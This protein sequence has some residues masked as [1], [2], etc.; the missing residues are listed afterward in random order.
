MSLPLVTLLA[1]VC[2]LLGGWVCW[3]RRETTDAARVESL[4][5]AVS[6]RTDGGERRGA[7]DARAR[8]ADRRP[9]GGERQPEESAADGGRLS[10]VVGTLYGREHKTSK[11]YG[12]MRWVTSVD[13][14]DI[15]ILYVIFGL[16]AGLWGATDAMMIR[17]ELFTPTTDVWDADTYNALFTTHGLTM[18]FFFVTPV[19]TGLANYFLPI[20]VDADDMA[21]PRINAIAFWLLPPS[22]VL[23]RAGLL[24]E[25][26]AKM[27][28]AVGPRI[29]FLYALEPPTPG[30]TLYVPR[31]VQLAN[32]QVDLLILGLHLSGLA[33]V[34]GAVNIIV[35]IFTERGE[36]VGWSNLDIFSWSLLTTSGIILFAF[37]LLGSALLM[38]LLD[39]NFGTTFFA[40]EAGGPILWQHLFWFFGHPEVYIL[41]LPAFGLTSQILPKFAGRRLF[42][43]KFIVYSTLAIGVL[44]FG[45]W[46]HHM[47]ATGIDPRLRAS[48]MA[49]SIAI[50]VPSAVKTFNWMATLWNGSVRLEAPMQFLIGGIGLF[51]VGG[52]TGIFLASI[53]VDL[54]LHGTYYIVAHFHFIVVGIIAFSMFAASYY[55]YPLLTGRMYDRR[56]ATVHSVLSIGGVMLTFFP[57]FLVG[58][59]GL[60]RRSAGYPAEFTLLQQVATVGAF[61]L[62]VSVGIWLFNMV[63]SFRTGGVVRDPDPWNLKETGQFSREWQWFEDRMSQDLSRPHALADGGR[64]T[65]DVVADEADGGGDA[66]GDGSADAEDD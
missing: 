22:F 57:L 51:V 65:G 56:L 54:V 14:K 59:M 17:T 48:F 38:L 12:L 16:A 27:I 9:D 4:S 62:A 28:D 29:E 6:L 37:P 32:P 43:F 60:P 66:E 41:V 5:D 20:M 33:T 47:F 26:L 1:A 49:V 31:A 8:D 35:T 50:A 63:N 15:G 45:V 55:W 7:D 40:V 18:L 61:V 13:H 44:S 2:A 3:R 19:F 36:D 34:M 58:L 10:S 53:P 30:W 64:E 46:A 25:V 21:F 23:V 42:G 52:V 39:R 24:T 11:P